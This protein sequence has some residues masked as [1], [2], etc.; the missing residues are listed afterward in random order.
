MG[1]LGSTDSQP[2]IAEN[3]GKN[4]PFLFICDHA[5]RE[6]PA[7]LGR[8]GLPAPAFDLH[9]AWDIGAAAVTR[10][11]A[12]S[13]DAPC[14][15]Q[16]YS[17]LVIDCNRDPASPGAIVGISDGVAIPGNQGLDDQARRAR[18]DAIHVP[19]HQAVATALDERSQTG[20]PTILVSMHS[21]TPRMGGVDRPWRFGVIREAGSR[22]SLRVLER[23]QAVGGFEVGDNLP[24]AMDGIDYSVPAHAL[25]R[26]ID[27]LE[28]EMRQD[29]IADE[30]SQDDTASLLR[31][32]LLR[33]LD[34]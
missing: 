13:L 4:A 29:T 11:L 34:G 21:F 5:G 32:V 26:G 8:L 9:I 19:Y 16:R 14:F 6:I 7:G 10:R 23:L 15:L 31:E 24:Y 28:L 1:L 2:V 27:Y 3:A 20:L 22:F 33:S 18:V 25:K 17:R 30:R 12:R